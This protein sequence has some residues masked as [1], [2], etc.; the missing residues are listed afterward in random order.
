MSRCP[1]CMR[2][3]GRDGSCS[4][5]YPNIQQLKATYALLPGTKLREGRFTLGLIKQQSFQSVAYM[6]WDE[7][8]MRPVVVTEFMPKN[9]AVR[10]NGQTVPKRFPDLYQKACILYAASSQAMPLPLIDSFE[11]NGTAYRVYSLQEN[12]TQLDESIDRLLDVPVYFRDGSGK[13][14]MNVC[15]LEI[16][17]MP[18]RREWRR[19]QRESLGVTE[20]TAN[21][22][23]KPAAA[24]SPTPVPAP[25]AKEKAP[26]PKKRRGHGWLVALLSVSAVAI[27]LVGYTVF[28][29]MEKH[30]VVIQI[31]A[32]TTISSAELNGE[33]LASPT[34]E[35]GVVTYR[36]QRQNGSY[37][38]TARGENGMSLEP[39]TIE[40]KS[41]D[42]DCRVVLPDPTATP[43]PRIEADE[44]RWIFAG[45]DGGYVLV[46]KDGM[47]TMI[48]EPA[49]PL[50][51]CRLALEG[52]GAEA[53]AELSF[54][55][56]S[57]GAQVPVV[58]TEKA[59]IAFEGS[60]DSYTLL[61]KDDAQ[62]RWL[63]IAEVTPGQ[64]CRVSAEALL[65]WNRYLQHMAQ[66]SALVFVG[67]E[68]TLGAAELAPEMLMGWASEYPALYG[69]FGVSQLRMA[70]DGRMAGGAQVM[71]SGLEWTPDAD[72]YLAG[73]AEE[74]PVTITV[75]DATYH[76]QLVT[77]E[78]SRGQVWTIGRQ[79]G[80]LVETEWK[81]VESLLRCGE[82]L[83][84]R[85]GE[86]LLGMEE[87]ARLMQDME[88]W[89]GAMPVSLDAMHEVRLVI[90]SLDVNLDRIASVQVDGVNVEGEI[91]GGEYRVAV[92]ATG[93]TA[94]VCVTFLN[95]DQEMKA[96]SLE[97]GSGKGIM[98]LQDVRKAY[99]DLADDLQRQ[100]S[101]II[102]TK[103]GQCFLLGDGGTA[104]TCELAGSMMTPPQVRRILE[105]YVLGAKVDEY[106]TLPVSIAL[107]GRIDRAAVRQVSLA[108]LSL[109]AE[110]ET[111]CS[112]EL[113]PGTYRVEVQLAGENGQ[114]EYTELQVKEGGESCVLLTAQADEAVQRLL[115]WGIAPD[116]L[117]LR[118]PKSELLT[119]EAVA[120]EMELRRGELIAV[121]LQL[122]EIG[123]VQWMLTDDQGRMLQVHAGDTALLTEGRYGLSATVMGKQLQLPENQLSGDG[124]PWQVTGTALAETL[125]GSLG[126][127]WADC[128]LVRADSAL[129]WDLWYMDETAVMPEE[130]GLP[131]VLAALAQAEG[132]IR[133]LTIV[134]ED[135][136]VEQMKLSMLVETVYTDEETPDSEK[137]GLLLPVNAA[138]KGVEV[139]SGKEL[140][141]QTN[142]KVIRLQAESGDGSV[143]QTAQIMMPELEAEKRVKL[144]LERTGDDTESQ[145]PNYNP[146]ISRRPATPTPE[147]T[148]SPAPEQTETPASTPTPTGIGESIPTPPVTPTSSPT[149]APSPTPTLSHAPTPN[150][151]TRT[152]FSK[153]NPSHGGGNHKKR[154]K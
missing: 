27:V 64:S 139:G 88:R 31:E 25:A 137:E 43:I 68:N 74:L 70:L 92:S 77:E 123:D 14:M 118:E 60:E 75:G 97:E 127:N 9:Q 54:A 80:D 78:A 132:S 99:L 81:H 63:E 57:K 109:L 142:A 21:P 66:D 41:S 129:E 150:E 93:G 120:A 13:P 18:K 94:E 39:V 34:I 8:Q 62:D 22:A 15:A 17:P 125:C 90:S 30:D 147:M 96:V 134:T 113:T 86:G 10:K 56:S 102:S 140:I 36:L 119:D 11:E 71:L 146:V 128:V 32:N 28:R 35:D 44:S 83:L 145:T 110:D 40:V 136:A 33:P 115:W 37:E 124:A 58:W 67:K 69:S 50:K 101:G 23:E 2:E 122:P 49:R 151:A 85:D 16:P 51:G 107:D 52:E 6:G 148:P 106:A 131:G 91:T 53:A 19:T 141:C 153:S 133:A 79:Q 89:P 103:D 111:S 130:P 114:M 98:L 73:D 84:A 55:V 26:A 7:Q 46:T 112:L 121:A 87:S 138:S 152:D 100:V 104:D 95:G 126:L 154:P 20:T 61:V 143:Y 76:E 117:T 108:G 105:N 24:P 12:E 45:A 149:S 42:V 59:E 1:N 144:W 3:L 48:G 72:V 38:L 4:C 135:A 47:E 65:C 116:G 29:M 82:Q 5:G